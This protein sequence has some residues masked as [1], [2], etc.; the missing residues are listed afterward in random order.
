MSARSGPRKIRIAAWLALNATLTAAVMGSVSRMPRQPSRISTSRNGVTTASACSTI[1]ICSDRALRS[2][3]PT[4]APTITG[5]P[6]APYAPAATLA[7]SDSMA[8][9]TGPKPSCTSSAAQIA[10]GTPKPAAPSRNA[11]NAK[12]ISSTCTR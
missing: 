5:M 10:I 6:I 2:T 3:P 9:L 4:W 12:L 1:T 8:A 11:P 7:T